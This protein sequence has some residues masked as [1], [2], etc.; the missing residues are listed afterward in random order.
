MKKRIYPFVSLIAV[1]LIM[2]TACTSEVT[3]KFPAEDG[4]LTLSLSMGDIS[5]RALTTEESDNDGSY[6]EKKIDRLDIFFYQGTTLKWRVNNLSYDAGT[7]KT[8][9]PVVAT[10]RALFENNTTT[11]YDVYVVAN[12]TADL[13][14]ITEEENNL[15]TLKDLVFQ[16]AS[17]VSD[18]GAVAQSSFVMDGMIS[19]IVNLNT[20]DLGMVHLKRAA[21]KIRLQLIEVNV[22]G[23]VQE[24]T[25]LAR[26][27]HFT[28]RSVLMDDGTTFVPGSADW[29]D[30]GYKELTKTLSGNIN[31]TAAP[32]YTY[33]NDWSSDFTKETYLELLIPLKENTGSDIGYY[34]YRVP[35]TPYGLT[36]DDQQYMNKVQRNFLYDIGVTVRIL[37][38]RDEP[39]VDIQGNYTIKDWSTQEILV[40][41]T[42]SHYLVVSER[43]VVMPN[44][45]SYTLNFN[46]SVANVMLVPNSLK[47]TYT[48][49]PAGA[50]SPDTVN[51]TGGQ[52]P[53][54]QVQS[55]VASGTIIIT[56]AI[57]ENYIPKDIE[58]QVT[59][60]QLTETVKIRQLPATYFSVTKG[61]RSYMP[62][63]GTRYSL[64]SG[65]NNP[66]MYAITTLAP[67][68]DIIWGFP[69]VD[70]QG[71]TINSEE[72]SKMV[73][74]KFEMASQFG[75]SVRK[76]YSDAQTQCR[77]YSETSEDGTTKTGWRL[78]TAAEIYYIDVLQQTAPTKYVM[79][80]PYYWSNWSQ[81]PTKNANG[82]SG[83]YGAYRM[84]ENLPFVRTDDT[85]NWNSGATYSSAHVRCIRDIKD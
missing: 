42:G 33:A 37:G 58:F 36:G 15:Q 21:S 7:Q 35:V 4:H 64:P 81:Y 48:Y 59:N 82:Q 3:E 10:K 68:G 40:T 5:T 46:S 76:S 77:G 32:F 66:Y 18:G 79:R 51:V 34:K 61:V 47:A 24:G 65:N 19:Q 52:V 25:A 11:T 8:T 67:K 50:S 62:G 63:E 2:A 30:T 29:K 17:F 78:P 75:A 53:S 85:Y 56:S 13:S 6:N 27:V 16:T 54:V 80:G 31:T 74:P 20:P 28:D 43:N 23:Y 45:S 44:M 72:V 49:V 1:M 60:G 84:R 12:N 41:I 70:S 55:G 38:S 14:S 69:P 71:Q 57:P 39:P 22:P 83:Y 73:S 26:L 9:I